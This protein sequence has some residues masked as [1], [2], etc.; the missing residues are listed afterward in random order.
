MSFIKF[1]TDFNSAKISD[2]PP[3]ASL[4]NNPC[5]QLG[6][7]ETIFQITDDKLNITFAGAIKVDLIGCNGNV[8]QNIDENFYYEGFQDRNG[9]YQIAFEFG[10][11]GKDYYEKDIFLKITDLVNGLEY[12]SN[13]F[14]VTDNRI[15]LSSKL[16]YFDQ[17]Y[18][19]GT[20]YDLMPYKQSVRLS[21][22]F[23]NNPENLTE[24]KEFTNSVGY[25][26]NYRNITTYLRKYI[27]EKL[28]FF[29]N[30]RL[31]YLFAH[32]FIYLNNQ[33]VSISEF[34][35]NERTSDV[36]WLTCDFLVNPKDEYI[37]D[38]LQLYPELT[39]VLNPLNGALLTTFNGLFTMTFNRNASIT[40]GS[41][42]KV[43]IN[44]SLIGTYLLSLAGNVVSFDGSAFTYISGEYSVV[45]LPNA[46]NGYTLNEWLFTIGTGDYDGTQYSNEYFIN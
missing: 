15:G 17:N 42:A 43:Y 12:F 11:I 20:S 46:I 32:P 24:F 34:K 5:I 44:G 1:F 30:D 36:N 38:A 21:N 37:N 2:N 31:S 33:R 28:D 3:V 13:V 16:I 4:F 25:Q 19:R 26:V 14:K 40:S 35:T 23:Y 45:I 22:C 7:D 29:T 41:V 8:L 6:T 18:F 27:F 39:A 10:F 9:I